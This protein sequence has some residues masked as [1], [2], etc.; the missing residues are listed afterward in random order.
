VKSRLLWLS[1]LI[2]VMLIGGYLWGSYYFSSLMIDRPT[3]TLAQSQAEMATVL[4]SLDLPTPEE[5]SIPAGDVTLAG[6]YYDNELDGRCA[7]LLLHG[8]TG[9]RYAA[10]QYAPLFWDRGCD[11]L[12]YDARGH[13]ASTPAYHTYGYHEKQDAK[14][15]YE[16]L[17]ARS[18]LQPFQV[19]LAGV[20]Y[21]AATSLQAAPL[22]P[23]AAFIIADSSYQDMRSIIT[24]QAVQMFGGWTKLF[25]PVAIF[26][27]Q[28]RAD[29]VLDEVSPQTAVTQT[30]IPIFLIHARGDDFTPYTHSET[31]YGRSNPST[32]Q[33]E[34]T[35][36]G[37]EHG[38]S[39]FA[40]P[41]AFAAL[42]DGF[43]SEYAPDFGLSSG[44]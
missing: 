2:D 30:T 26:F 15:A 27:A 5:V 18:G 9:T 3:M 40:D 20:S 34:I 38:M 12:A 43:L 23:G 36:W 28:Q 11:L 22:L 8:Y 29:F 4:P 24:Y 13:G 41:D 14:A 7:M 1:F 10:L 33:L 37:A 19:G 6:F 32:T 17:L 44:R 21:G 25:L 42:V 39:I 16:W 35:D 31:I